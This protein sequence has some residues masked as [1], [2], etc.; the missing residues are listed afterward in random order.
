MTKRVA[1]AIIAGVS[2]ALG[3][4]LYAVLRETTYIGRLFYGSE[5]VA[6]LRNLVNV[7]KTYW[8]AVYL[9]DF[10][11]ALSLSCSLMVLFAPSLKG[12]YL[13]ALTAVMC[14]LL[15]EVLQAVQIVSGTGD[16]VDVALFFLAG[17]MSV[18]IN[19]KERGI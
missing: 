11:W 9:P 18:I 4:L 5:F 16:L 19:L 6:V 10:L 1:N 8:A 14:G 7:D 17:A 13:C 2:L 15:W 12:I 3:G